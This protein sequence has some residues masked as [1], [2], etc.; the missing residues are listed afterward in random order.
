MTLEEIAE[1]FR[2]EQERKEKDHLAWIEKR[3][4]E[5]LEKLLELSKLQKSFL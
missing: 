2:K 5:K 4:K 3:N 1:H